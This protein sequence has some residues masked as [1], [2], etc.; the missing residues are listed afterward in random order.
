MKLSEETGEAGKLIA[1]VTVDSQGQARDVVVYKSS[2][3]E[4][5][6]IAAR[7]LSDETYKPAIC[8]GQP[9]TMAFVLR[10]QLLERTHA[11]SER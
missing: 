6:T 3:K 4:A 5:T 1:S 2:S 8:K 11:G 7:A 10:V 9:C